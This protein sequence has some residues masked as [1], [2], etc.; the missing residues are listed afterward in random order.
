MMHWVVT[1]PLSTP[2][3]ICLYQ[4]RALRY[5]N[6]PNCCTFTPS[7]AGSFTTQYSSY[8][9]SE[10]TVR[11]TLRILHRWTNTTGTIYRGFKG[12]LT[13]SDR[14]TRHA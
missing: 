7:H 5:F 10:F 12:R 2:G 9:D 1:G 8:A 6:N 14:Q 4:H 13:A 11:A 3:N